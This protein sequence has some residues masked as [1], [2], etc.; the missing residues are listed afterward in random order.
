MKIMKNF[1]PS[2]KKIVFYSMVFWMVL[3]PEPNAESAEKIDQAVEVPVAGVGEI[4]EDFQT[5]SPKSGY[6]VEVVK[7]PKQN[8]KPAFLSNVGFFDL[9]GD[10]SRKLNRSSQEPSAADRG[11]TESSVSTGQ[12][13]P[14]VGEDQ[15]R[16]ESSPR[17][18]TTSDQA[19]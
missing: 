10:I 14:M 18:K 8:R 6:T 15:P 9:L 7:G 11:H 3:I 5:T 13:K 1:S 17:S 12:A 19:K 4:K 16:S 2:Q